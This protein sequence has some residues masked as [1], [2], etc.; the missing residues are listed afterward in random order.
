VFVEGPD[1]RD[2]NNIGAVDPAEL[3]GGKRVFHLF[4]RTEDHVYV[5]GS[6][7]THI[8]EIRLHVMDSGEIDF[9]KAPV[10]T[11]E[12]AGHTHMGFYN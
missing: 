9:L 11:D 6:D 1:L 12:K 4:Q 7:D 8:V 2:R 5:I 3:R 10:M